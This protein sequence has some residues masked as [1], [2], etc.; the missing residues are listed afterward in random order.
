MNQTT[1][2]VLL[3]A[4]GWQIGEKYF[5]LV[6]FSYSNCRCCL[7]QTQKTKIFRHRCDNLSFSRRMY[8]LSVYPAIL[9]YHRANVLLYRLQ[10]NKGF[11]SQND[12]EKKNTFGVIKSLIQSSF[13]GQIGGWWGL[14]NMLNLY[15]KF[16]LKNTKWTSY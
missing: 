16:I 5:H 13:A 3:N 12:K 10:L 1:H 8:S 15:D 7:Q 9:A 2:L 11:I 4:K 6:I 14:S